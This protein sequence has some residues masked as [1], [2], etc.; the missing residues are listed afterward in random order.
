M[1]SCYRVLFGNL[2]QEDKKQWASFWKL[3]LPPK[4]K[5]FFWQAC[6]SCLPTKDLLISRRVNC[7]NLCPMCSSKQESIW[8][9]FVDCSYAKDLWSL[10]G[11]TFQSS[12]TQTFHE[13]FSFNSKCLIFFWWAKGVKDPKQRNG[14]LA[15]STSRNLALITIKQHLQDLR[16]IFPQRSTPV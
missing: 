9:L 3:K 6:S 2:R 10:L 4:V 16:R 11:Y 1:K 8:H 5:M 15:P 7:D 12:S 13:W 14:T